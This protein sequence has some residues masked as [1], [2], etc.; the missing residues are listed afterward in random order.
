MGLLLITHD[1]AV[2]SGMAHQVA[3]MYAGQIVEVAQRGGV[4]RVAAPPL[5][6]RAAARAARH[7]QARRRAGGDRRH[8]AAAVA[9][10]RRAAASRRAAT[11]P[12]TPA[13]RT[14][15]ELRA[16]RRRAA[17]AACCTATA[18]A[19]RRRACRPRP[20]LR[21]E[22]AARPRRADEPLLDVRDLSRAL[23][24]PQAACCSARA[25]AFD[26]VDG[27]SFSIPRRP[28]AGAGR[29]VG[30]RQDDHRQGDRAAAAPPGA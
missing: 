28:H 16:G 7:R 23:P 11:A 5:R 27:V 15:P 13:T 26:A 18:P 2:V 25:G 20:P 22:R 4:L 29:R 6:A 1:L 21:Y 3:L 17:C 19:R 12:S 9:G 24:D 8:G 10:L 30:L 14:L